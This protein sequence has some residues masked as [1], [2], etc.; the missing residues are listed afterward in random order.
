[1]AVDWTNAQRRAARTARWA[2][3]IGY[4]MLLGDAGSASLDV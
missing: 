2:V 3:T 4:F 1:M